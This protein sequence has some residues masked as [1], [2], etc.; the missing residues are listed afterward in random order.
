[1][2][3]LTEQYI[4]NYFDALQLL[5]T[6]RDKFEEIATDASA[7]DSQRATAAAAYLDMVAQIAHLK[8]AHEAF[9][10]RYGPSSTISPTA[11]IIARA[12]ELHDALG[13]VIANANTQVAMIH[14]VTDFVNE[15]GA[16]SAGSPSPA[17]AA[18]GVPQVPTAKVIAAGNLAFL[19]QKSST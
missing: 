19:G 11:E 13:A 12:R 3:Q 9:M 1:M 7:T 15:W 6:E 18:P 4:L 8:D 10:R 17:A 16:L 2:A 14:A 5:Q